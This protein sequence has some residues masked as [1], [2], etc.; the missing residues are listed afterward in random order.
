MNKSMV[1]L[2]YDSEGVESNRYDRQRRPIGPATTE[3]GFAWL[4]LAEV[5]DIPPGK[6]GINWHPY[7]RAR[8]WLNWE[9]RNFANFK[10]VVGDP[11]GFW[12]EFATA[13]GITA[14]EEISKSPGKTTFGQ[15]PPVFE[16]NPVEIRGEIPNFRGKNQNYRG[17]ITNR[18][19]NRLNSS[20]NVAPSEGFFS[21]P[22]GQILSGGENAPTKQGKE[23]NFYD[24][25]ASRGATIRGNNPNFSK[26]MTPGGGNLPT[27]Q[28]NE[29]QLYHSMAPGVANTP[30]NKGKNPSFSNGMA[31]GGE[32]ATIYRGERSDFDDSMTSDGGN[33]MKNKGNEPIFSNNMASGGG[34][35]STKTGNRPSWAQIARD[36]PRG[37]RVASNHV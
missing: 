10:Y 12:K 5:T 16:S 11:L 3:H 7:M 31:S 26:S 19:G 25:V 35:M 1:L 28:G 29:P 14:V 15:S 4:N 13:E 9:Y 30:T 8:H 22:K 23:R 18:R 36:T 27:N 21:N 20:S 6:N 37:A 34:N 17:N 33:A 32:N 2:A 24:I